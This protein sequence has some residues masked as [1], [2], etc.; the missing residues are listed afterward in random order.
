ME[1]L[2]RPWGRTARGLTPWPR[3]RYEDLMPAP[4]PS[5]VLESLRS[6]LTGLPGSDG[7][8]QS[9]RPAPLLVGRVCDD[10]PLFCTEAAVA[11]A[12]PERLLRG[13]GAAGML[14]GAERLALAVDEE[15][16]ELLV[17][18]R[19][20]TSGSRVEIW[21]V[22]PRVPLDADCLLADLM[23]RPPPRL[24]A[25]PGRALLGRALVLDAVVL[26][27][28]ALIVEGRPLLHRAVTVCGLVGRPSVLLCALGTPLGEVVRSAGGSSD[29]SGVIFHNGL[30][31]GAPAPPDQSVELHTRGLLVLPHD[32]PALAHRSVPVDDELRRTMSACGACRACSD[33]CTAHLLGASLEPHRVLRAA[34]A[35]WGRPAQSLDAALLG[36]LECRGCGLCNT[37]CP[38]GLRPATV[39]DAVARRLRQQ[40]TELCRPTPLQP[41]GDRGGRR[42]SRRRLVERLGLS[43][44]GAPDPTIGGAVLPAELRVAARGPGGAPRVPVVRAGEPVAMGDL[45]ALA[46]A[47]S[48]GLDVRSPAPGRVLSID[49]DDGILLSVC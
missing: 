43:T 9:L 10:E 2:G 6:R 20:A 40:G 16:S 28:L 3:R 41:H 39:V 27:D 8:I 47:G 49:P 38:S 29:P 34:G 44:F 12:W 24:P 30:L 19:R 5:E 37:A 1:G 25:E 46:P 7:R 45:L 17:A 26:S 14:C 4:V 32:H 42:L 15:Q 11:R 35:A 21:P 23:E 33:G 36:A 22:A 18:L 48:G 13:L 31:A